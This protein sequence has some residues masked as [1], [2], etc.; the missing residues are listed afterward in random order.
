MVRAKIHQDSWRHLNF[1]RVLHS[2]LGRFE[3]RVFEILAENGHREARLKHLN[4]TRNLDLTG[5]RTTELARRAGVTK[6]AMGEI[7]EQCEQLGLIR[8]EVDKADARAKIVRFTDL[9][10]EWLEAFRVAIEKAE[11][12][13]REELGYLRCD[14]IIASLH[15]YGEHYDVLGRRANEETEGD[16]D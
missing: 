14:A 10:L 7:V 5:T 4:L 9:G 15:A 3:A 8:R 16:E 11:E 13:V 12:E 2:A 1:G 6:Q